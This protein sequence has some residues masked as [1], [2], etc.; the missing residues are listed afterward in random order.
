MFFENA[1]T[2]PKSSLVNA[3]DSVSLTFDRCSKSRF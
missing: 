1:V 3:T 2:I